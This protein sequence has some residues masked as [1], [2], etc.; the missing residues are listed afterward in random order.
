VAIEGERK[1]RAHLLRFNEAAIAERALG[2]GPEDVV[3][4]LDASDEVGR[5]LA[6]GV[7]GK[8]ETDRVVAE[9]ARRSEIPTL[10]V[11]VERTR[12]A[13]LTRA[14][15]PRLSERYSGPPPD[16]EVWVL[17]VA[18]GGATLASFPHRPGGGGPGAGLFLEPE[19][20]GED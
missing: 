15:W 12:L 4:V 2:A 13:R 19:G 3:L 10:I 5:T 20:G 6:H 9:S 14:R 11:P 16:G 17:V 18:H 1:D 8:P 7:M